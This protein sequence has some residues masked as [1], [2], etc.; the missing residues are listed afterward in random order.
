MVDHISSSS[1][2]CFPFCAILG[3]SFLFKDQAIYLT[4]YERIRCHHFL[5]LQFPRLSKGVS[6]TRRRRR[7]RLRCRVGSFS[8]SFLQD[9]CFPFER[10]RWRLCTMPLCQILK[11]QKITSIILDSSAKYSRK[12]CTVELVLL[13]CFGVSGCHVLLHVGALSLDT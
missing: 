10:R 1:S 2:R 8:A 6:R 12:P 13:V 4:T 5:G 11:V 9:P 3:T 7:V